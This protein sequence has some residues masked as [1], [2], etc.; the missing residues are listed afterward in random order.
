MFWGWPAE[1]VVVAFVTL[2]ALFGGL[3]VL[4]G[5]VAGISGHMEAVAAK[6]DAAKANERAGEANERAAEL[7]KTAAQLRLDLERERS[8]TAARA[9]TTEQFDA[10]QAVRGVVKDVGLLW[11]SHCVECQLF[12]E[13]IAIALHS[14]GVQLYGS[15]GSEPRGASSTGIF[16]LLPAGS[17]L[18]KH[19]LVVALTNAGLNPIASFPVEEF[20]K[21]RTDIPVIFVEERIPTWLS[22][23]YQPPGTTSWRVLPIEKQ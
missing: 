16:V 15:H 14:A 23:P 5:L 2:S 13:N 19:P 8:R 21:I 9:W 6:V 10:L 1:S 12:A 17:D 18:M 3:A 20:S 7:D 4:S 22:S 11:E